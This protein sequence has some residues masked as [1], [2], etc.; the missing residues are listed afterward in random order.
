MQEANA[1]AVPDETPPLRVLRVYHS[2]VVT[3]WRQRDREL[4]RLGCDVRLV[5]PLHWNEGGREVVLDAGSDEFVIPTPTW[6]RHPYGFLYDPRPIARE[7]RCRPLD[8]VDLHEEPASLAAFELRVLVW[9]FR[10]G[11]PIV[12]YGAQNIEKRYP[13]PSRWIERGSLRRARGAHCCNAEAAAIFARKGLRG[14]TRVIGLGVDVDRFAPA[15]ET[16]AAGRFRLGYVGR[17]EPHKGVDVVI[18]AVAGLDAVELHVYGDGP[19]RATLEAQ[20][21]QLHLG[22][23]VQFHG[24]LADSE[25]PDAYRSIDALAVPSRATPRW[26]E[27][28]GRVA[29]EAMATGVPVIAS[30][31]G[32]LPE[33]VGDAGILVPADAVDAWR[34][35]I[36][37]LAGNRREC[38]LLSAAGRARAY[39]WSWKQIARSHRDFY[40]EVLP[41]RASAD[42]AR[43]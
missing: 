42:L 14:P 22:D 18:E 10:R 31:T 4:R 37:S 9:L 40:L 38:A 5:S 34:Y 2:A 8:I 29:V 35:A 20:S 12:F 15:T 24:F 32:A 27:Q 26:I 30:G 25:L 11:T 3:G 28:F 7:L 17:L 39:R 33:V 23:R 16:R 19:L 36:A 41:V 21:Q 6:G 13:I 1:P 43:V